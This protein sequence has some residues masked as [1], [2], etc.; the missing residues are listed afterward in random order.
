MNISDQRKYN[1]TTFTRYLYSRIEAKQ[2]LFVSLLQRDISQALFWGYELYYSG[3][4]EETYEF[5]KDIYHEIYEELNPDLNPFID[6]MIEKWSICD[7]V[8]NDSN[9]GSIIYTLSQRKYNLVSFVKSILNYSITKEH[10]DGWNMPKC[11]IT[12][13]PEH[14]EQYK[15]RIVSLDND[16]KSYNILKEVKLYPAIKEYNHLFDT[17]MPSEFSTIYHSTLETWLFYAA[18]SP[19]WL[20]RILH[21]NGT[22]D[23]ETNS[24]TFENDDDENRFCKLWDYEPNEL[25]SHISELSL[26]TGKEKQQTIKQ[27]CKKFNHTITCKVTKRKTTVS[28]KTG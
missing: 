19:I 18:R 16:E 5:V 1:L 13:L 22:I 3:F 6:N 8:S 10:P 12:L 20:N 14:I 26:G 15:T 25:P 11:I 9:L 21:Y 7:N 24:V 28:E 23:N 17:Q 2:S 4:E 27:F